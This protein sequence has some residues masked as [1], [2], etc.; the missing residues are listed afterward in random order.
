MP[1]FPILSWPSSCPHP[2]QPITVNE[3]GEITSMPGAR[4]ASA[5]SW[6]N[7][8]FQICESYYW[9]Y[10]G[11]F[12]TTLSADRDRVAAW[13]LQTS[14]SAAKVD[15]NTTS[16]VNLWVDL[17]NHGQLAF[18]TQG[19]SRKLLSTAPRGSQCHLHVDVVC[20]VDRRDL[21]GVDETEVDNVYWN[22]GVI[23]RLQLI[24]N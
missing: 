1:F 6:R 10:I 24:P 7:A 15:R 23:D 2:I 9:R 14:G 20:R 8:P 3:I 18:N 16:N 11:K 13:Q 12:G 17:W 5:S 22:L 21:A 4:P 19:S